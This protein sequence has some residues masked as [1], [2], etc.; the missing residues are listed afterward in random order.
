MRDSEL[1]SY[2]EK[3]NITQ[4][5]NEWNLKNCL[6]L[7]EQRHL[8]KWVEVE[9]GELSLASVHQSVVVTESCA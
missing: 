5:Q 9:I 8:C 7:Y 1:C 6:K 2:L 3:N 4:E